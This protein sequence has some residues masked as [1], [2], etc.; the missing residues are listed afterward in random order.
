VG[1]IAES[2]A[3]T[4]TAPLL[5]TESAASGQVMEGQ[6]IVKIPVMQKAFKRITLYMPNM[7]I[8]NG[9][10]AVDSVSERSHDSG[11]DQRSR[12]RAW[13]DE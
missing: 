6:T 3:V 13:W 9:Q 1:S 5:E 12:A 4:A 7:N 8:I 11:W 10:H 2:I